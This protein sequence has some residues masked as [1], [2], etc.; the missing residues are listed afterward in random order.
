M[1]DE[2]SE[3]G[4]ISSPRASNRENNLDK[5]VAPAGNGNLSERKKINLKI[6]IEN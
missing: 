1:N 3:I 6:S 4:L 2:A 5:F